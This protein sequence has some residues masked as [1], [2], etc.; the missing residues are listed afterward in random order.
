MSRRAVGGRR[1]EALRF[2]RALAA[3]C[4]T[5]GVLLGATMNARA[6]TDVHVMREQPPPAHTGGFDEPT[7]QSCHFEAEINEGPGT[8]LVAGL[9]S[10][11]APDQTYELTITMVQPG[12]AAGGFQLAAR[13]AA[14]GRQAGVLGVPAHDSMRTAITVQ[15]DVSYAHHLGDGVDPATAD[16]ARWSLLW[17]APAGDSPDRRDTVVF[18]VV[19]N[20][21]DDDASPL[22]DLIYTATAQ[23]TRH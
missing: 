23:T 5:G 15:D 13:Y 4:C 7:C 2:A 10:H 1:P 12:L 3:C 22:G 14:T 11:Y 9:P 6:T 16:T 20:A 19:A 18:H 8:L 21:A 17:K